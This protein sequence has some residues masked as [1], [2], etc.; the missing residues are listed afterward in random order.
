MCEWCTGEGND[1]CYCHSVETEEVL[2]QRSAWVDRM[3]AENDYF[4]KLDTD[5]GYIYRTFRD[6]PSEINKF[7]TPNHIEF[8]PQST[9][10]RRQYGRTLTEELVKRNLSVDGSLDDRREK[11]KKV[12]KDERIYISWKNGRQRYFD[13]AHKRLIPVEWCVPCV[14]HMHNRITEKML[15]CLLKKGYI[16]KITRN[17]KEE[18]VSCIEDTINFAILGT[19]HSR[20]HFTVPLTDDK[21]DVSS[22]ISLIDMQAKK[23]MVNID[24]II[25]ETFNDTLNIPTWEQQC[26]DWTD[27]FVLFQCINKI[28]QSRVVFDDAMINDYSQ[29]LYKFF[30]EWL[31]LAGEEG[32]TNYIHM[33]GS[34]HIRFYLTRYR[35]LYKFSQQGWEQLNK[36]ANGIYHRHSQKGGNGSGRAHAGAELAKS[37]IYPVFRFFVRTWMWKTKHG[38][39]VFD[40]N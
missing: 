8:Q 9:N 39:K 16:C 14:F 6:S 20:A 13:T 19:E 5:E 12:L 27:V 30:C 15:C 35:N 1:K 11:L 31:K 23:I 17:E 28:H 7:S 10:D 37:Q 3:T 40:P 26:Q 33:I 29:R 21:A 22:S 25:A 34:G 36:R 24:L 32:V 4:S 18:Y 38:E 2:E